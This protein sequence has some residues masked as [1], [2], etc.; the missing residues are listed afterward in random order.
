MQTNIVNIAAL[1]TFGILS[2]LVR[3]S[4]IAS[5]FVCPCI[6]TICFYY[7]AWV[8]YD[9]TNVSIYYTMIVGI[10][11]SF[12]ILI[13]FNEVWIIS[14]AVYTPLLAFY[15]WQT[16]TDMVGKEESELYIRCV[17]CVFLYAIVAYKVESLNKQAFLGN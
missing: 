3:C 7:F 5:W 10:S 6:T 11:T 13:I 9:G 1:L 8:D 2:C 16:G 4:H 12:F 15:M 14:T 17:F